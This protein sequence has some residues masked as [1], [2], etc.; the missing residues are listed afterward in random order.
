MNP[1]M[2]EQ[3]TEQVMEEQRSVFNPTDVAAMTKQG[4]L[5][6]RMS[7]IDYLGQL[8]ID[9]NGPATQLVQFAKQQMQKRNP[10]NKMQA[11]AGSSPR[12]APGPQQAPP[13]APP[14]GGGGGGLSDLLNKMQ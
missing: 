2:A 11:L 12:P 1:G 7:V 5:N 13:Q 14:Q 9:P 10:M 8:G 4:K 6:P 3:S